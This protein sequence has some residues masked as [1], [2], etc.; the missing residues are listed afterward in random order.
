MYAVL[1][2]GELEQYYEID[3]SD[4]W[5]AAAAEKNCPYRSGWED[6]TLGNIFAFLLHKGDIKPS[7]IKSGIE[8]M[9]WLADWYKKNSG[10]AGVGFF[11]IGGG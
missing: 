8:Y 4:S 1:K 11:Q 10:G 6:S 2:S 5:M 3:P 7:I 9:T